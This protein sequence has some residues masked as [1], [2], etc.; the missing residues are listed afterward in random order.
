[1]QNNKLPESIY[2]GMQQMFIECQGKKSKNNTT[3][4][5]ELYI[6]HFGKFT[7]TEPLPYSFL[8]QQLNTPVCASVI[9]LL[10]VTS[11]RTG[12]PRWRKW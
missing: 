3:R 2:F 8:K 7:L 12:L 6:F 10:F 4:N 9:L 11:R 1:M 5:A